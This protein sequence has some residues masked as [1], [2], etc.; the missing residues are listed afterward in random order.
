MP[1]E[2][3]PQKRERSSAEIRARASEP[4]GQTGADGPWTQIPRG[5]VWE[6]RRVAARIEDRGDRSSQGAV[7]ISVLVRAPGDR[8]DDLRILPVKKILHLEADDKP[9]VAEV[10]RLFEV[11]VDNEPG[12]A[13]GVEAVAPGR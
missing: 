13:K 4:E 9:A 8:V 1:V 12:G 6:W 11:Q 2:R 5:I 7:R 10:D 3:R